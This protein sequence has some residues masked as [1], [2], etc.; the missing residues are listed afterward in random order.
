MSQAS[1]DNLCVAI[2]DYG[3]GNLASVVNAFNF[4]GIQSTIAG[5]IK[6]LRATDAIILPGVGAFGQAMANLRELG[7][8]EF[9]REK[10]IGDK[11]PFLGICL[12]MQLLAEKSDELGDHTGLG[13][14]DGDVTPIPKSEGSR[15]PHVGWSSVTF[16]P[17][18]PLFNGIPESGAFY[19]DHSYRL[20]PSEHTTSIVE[21]G[22]PISASIQDGNIFATQFHPEKSQ[23]NGLKLL[24]NFSN[25][26]LARKSAVK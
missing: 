22:E 8:D 7:F 12:G 14:I 19:F 21:Y 5:S 1:D 2:V 6:E 17:S 11:V 24:R 20:A 15:V 18:N 4:L 3:M 13:W 10:V 16:E 23:R 26:C 9:L 25:Y